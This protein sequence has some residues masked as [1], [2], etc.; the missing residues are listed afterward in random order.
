MP[1]PKVKN[2]VTYWRRC[3]RQSGLPLPPC[4]CGKPSNHVG[5]C[6]EKPLAGGDPK[7]VPLDFSTLASRL[8]TRKLQLHYRIGH[9]TLSRWFNDLGISAVGSGDNSTALR[10]A[11][12]DLASQG[13]SPRTIVKETGGKSETVR[14]Y[15]RTWRANVRAAGASLPPCRCGGAHNHEHRCFEKLCRVERQMPVDFPDVARNCA[16]VTLCRNYRAGNTTVSRWLSVRPDIPRPR[17]GSPA[18][19]LRAIFRPT[20]GIE[21]PTY[22]LIEKHVANGY[23]ADVRDDLISALYLAVL[24][25]S[26]RVDE[27]AVRGGAILNQTLRDCGV[28]R[29][30]ILESLDEVIGGNGFSLGE[31]VADEA[32]DDVFERL[33]DD[34]DF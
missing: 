23:A 15:V 22:A 2:C 30:R 5:R 12:E 34:Q 17:P 6:I 29:W 10:S 8:S 33:F 27:I 26:L 28:D 3:L 25:G 16:I 11:V 24:D 7:P 18:R 19:A 9:V 13:W 1:L 14:R 21:D 31:R 4:V 32:G 20:S